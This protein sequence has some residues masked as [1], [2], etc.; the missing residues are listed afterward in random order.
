MSNPEPA[1]DLWT[2]SDLCTPWCIRV[3][4]TLHIAEHIASG[5]TDIAAL[6][7]ATAS[8]TD[9]LHSVLSYLVARGVFIEEVPGRFAL[10]DTAQGLL[11]AG[12]F[13]GLD[14]IGGRMTHVWSTLPSYVRTGKPG[15]ADVFGAPFWD[16]LAAHPDVAADFDALMGYMGHGTPDAALKLARG[17]WED[18][19]TLV[20]VGG[21]TGAM[22]AALLRAQP[23]LRGMLVDL[24][25]PV[26][27]SREIF[28]AAGVADRV[29]SVAQSFF[30]PL[31]A[32]ADVYLLRKVLNDWPDRETVEILRRCADA[33]RPSG[34]IVAIGGV[35]P[36]GTP[37]P[38]SVEMLLVGGRT[39]TLPEFRELARQA[40]LEIVA[41]ESGLSHFLIE[42]RPL[43]TG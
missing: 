41:T 5:V 40:D 29:T 31:P 11:N 24:P 36:D 20:D 39:N 22:L 16:D 14:G 2:L 25:G 1:V 18:V 32:G 21:G 12:L 37:R 26:T 17:G 7:A 15:Y 35:V 33:A 6:A 28:E 8:D 43:V 34:T 19:H 4:V 42:C 9:A 27:R 3:V 23:H 13:L 38:L 30:D 10:N